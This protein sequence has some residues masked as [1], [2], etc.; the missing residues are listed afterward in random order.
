MIEFVVP[1]IVLQSILRR[2]T[3]QGSSHAGMKVVLG[4]LIVAARANLR[5]YVAVGRSGG[6][7]EAQ[8]NADPYKSNQAPRYIAEWVGRHEKSIARAGRV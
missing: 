4:D 6:G 5:V 2:G 3:E 8:P 1:G 7:G